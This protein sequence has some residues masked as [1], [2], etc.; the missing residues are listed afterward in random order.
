MK[1][2][3][4]HR[5]HEETFGLL[6]YFTLA[7]KD[8]EI[9]K[10]YEE[11]RIKR[12]DEMFKPMGFLCLTFLVGGWVGTMANEQVVASGIGTTLQQTWFLTFIVSHY[13]FHRYQP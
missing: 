11:M 3:R 9:E 10:E 8:P 7:I 12:M 6:N 5:H 13:F 2:Y 1:F 4:K